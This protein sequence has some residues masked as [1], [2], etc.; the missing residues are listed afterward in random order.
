MNY[1]DFRTTAYSVVSSTPYYVGVLEDEKQYALYE[2]SIREMLHMLIRDL[3]ELERTRDDA[4]L[5][6]LEREVPL[7][8]ASYVEVSDVFGLIVLR[9][10]LYDEFYTNFLNL[11]GINI[12][13]AI[14]TEFEDILTSHT[15]PN[16]LIHS[17]DQIMD[18]RLY[19]IYL[20]MVQLHQNFAS[21]G[22]QSFVFFPILFHYSVILPLWEQI[23]MSQ[24]RSIISEYLRAYLQ[25]HYDP[26]QFATMLYVTLLISPYMWHKILSETILKLGVEA[27]DVI[28]LTVDMFQD[29]NA[30]PNILI[31]YYSK[32]ITEIGR[33]HV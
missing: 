20:A 32:L 23:V 1:S 6:I 12:D 22:F 19:T 25:N 30:D 26:Q 27:N 31:D 9:K 8:Y 24:N 10:A 29:Q 17:T 18:V 3:K 14:N 4:R 33:A 15:F 7:M 16:T 28:D 13:E 2:S 5:A 11:Y 21:E